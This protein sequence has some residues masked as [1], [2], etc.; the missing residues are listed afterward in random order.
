MSKTRKLLY[1]G[2]LLVLLLVLIFLLSPYGPKPLPIV[3]LL[4]EEIAEVEGFFG[5][6]ERIREFLVSLGPYSLA[7]FIVLQAAQVVVS[8]IPGELTGIVGGY[9]YGVGFG[10]VLSTVGLTLGTWIVFELARILGRPFVE[11]VVSRS[12]LNKFTFLSTNAGALICFLLFAF[13][14]FPKDY[15]SYLLGVSRMGFGTFM[16]VSTIGRM[17]GTYLLS[18]QGANIRN[19]AYLSFAIVA[20]ICGAIVLVAYLYRERFFDWLK[21]ESQSRRKGSGS[22]V[23]SPES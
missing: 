5:S 19:E 4:E 13:P 9:V 2:L 3:G 7:V 21:K 1:R 16:V 15:L 10:F 23:Q 22:K 20:A 18:L 14:G 17:P 6:Q 8:P 12:V 11:R